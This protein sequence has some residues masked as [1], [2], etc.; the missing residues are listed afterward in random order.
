MTV[1]TIGLVLAKEVFQ[2]HYVTGVSVNLE[3]YR[4]M[5]VKFARTR[6]HTSYDIIDIYH[7]LRYSRD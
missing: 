1:K 5:E 2:V 3:S 4:C 7:T 6:T